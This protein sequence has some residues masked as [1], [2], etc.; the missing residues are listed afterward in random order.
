MT[1]HSRIR[2]LIRRPDVTPTE[3]RRRAERQLGPL[4]PCSITG[5][6]A[7][8]VTT[9]LL[10]PD[11]TVVEVF[12]VADE[13]GIFA[14]DLG[15]AYGWLW[16]ST[17]WRDF[18]S[19][20]R[21]LLADIERSTDAEFANGE[22]RRRCSGGESLA[23]SVHAVATAMLRFADLKFTLPPP[24]EPLERPGCTSAEVGRWLGERGIPFRADET[25]RGCSGRSWTAD[26]AIEHEGAAALVF[27]LSADSPIIA[28]ETAT[29]VAAASRDIR[30]SARNAAAH[31]LIALF[32][33][34]VEVWTPSDYKLLEPSAR[35]ARWTDRDEFERILRTPAP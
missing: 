16:C 29:A 8:R 19:G 10:L 4:Y 13:R 3:L 20:Q 23:E 25:V 35:V 34:A 12:L 6:G 31:R 30:E 24:G 15:D 28:C 17:A 22:F 18:S 9:P 1:G 14:T 32:D 5:E 11:R 27:L 2:R 7:V 26:F 33:D 21:R